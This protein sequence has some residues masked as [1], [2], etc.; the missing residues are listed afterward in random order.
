MDFEVHSV[1]QVI[2][3]RPATA[4]RVEFRPLY[5]TLNSDEGHHGRYFSV[6]REQRLH[7]DAARK[8]GSRTPYVGT[9]V[10]LSLVDQH[11]APY[12]Q[13]MPYLSVRA[14]LT[15]RDLPCLVPRDGHAD[16]TVADSIPVASVGLVRA[17]SVPKAPFAQREIAWRLIRQLGFDHLP[18]ADMP[19]REGAQA[20]RDML[21]LFVAADHDAHRRQIDALV[22]SRIEPVTRRLPGAGP[23]IYG[24][25][26]A[27]TL[28]VDEDGF[29]G[30]S[31]YLFGLV[32]ERYLARHVSIN[33]FTQTTLESMQRG[34]VAR[35][36]A[37]M[38]GRDIV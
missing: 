11:E 26:V 35:W 37:R 14:L 3:Q 20:L 6:R 13:D 38:G 7:S 28:R 5:Q 30:T 23:L 36:P 18:L 31:P 16:L 19:H 25:G 9:E 21:G 22:G 4:R 2:G 17:P 10:F 24:R 32:M 1:A 27:C 34:A 12:P 8:Y 29:S 33:V 15:N